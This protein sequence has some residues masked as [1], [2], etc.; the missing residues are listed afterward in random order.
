[1]A[2]PPPEW[3]LELSAEL[4]QWGRWGDDD[5]IGTLNLIDGDAVRRGAASV[6][7]GRR[8]SLATAIRAA[9]SLATAAQLIPPS[10]SPMLA[11]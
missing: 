11:A 6:Q 7:D 2:A 3:F 9:G 1:M 5:R 10:L 4:R 8:F